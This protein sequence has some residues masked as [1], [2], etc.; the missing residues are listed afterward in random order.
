MNACLVP[1]TF[2]VNTVS[3]RGQAEEQE[4]GDARSRAGRTARASEWAHSR[5]FSDDETAGGAA[6]PGPGRSGRSAAAASTRGGP[7]GSGRTARGSTHAVSPRAAGPLPGTFSGR[8]ACNVGTAFS[9][10]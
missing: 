4:G 10:S 3:A 8:R 1:F 9:S 6:A 2:K 7:R 5:V